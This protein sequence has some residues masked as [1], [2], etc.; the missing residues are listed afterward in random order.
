MKILSTMLTKTVNLYKSFMRP[1]RKL[2]LKLYMDRPVVLFKGKVTAEDGGIYVAKDYNG[3]DNVILLAPVGEASAF[4]A[5]VWAKP[6]EFQARQ[7]LV[8]GGGRTSA[9]TLRVHRNQGLR[10]S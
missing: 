9:Q 6:S 8:L 7:Q 5:P 10:S 4:S 2:T 3:I 1:F